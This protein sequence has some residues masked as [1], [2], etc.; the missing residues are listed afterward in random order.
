[1][2]EA[3]SP[4]QRGNNHHLG[5]IP[6]TRGNHVL[7]SLLWEAIHQ[8]LEAGLLARVCFIEHS[9]AK[10]GKLGIAHAGRLRVAVA[11]QTAMAESYNYIISSRLTAV[12]PGDDK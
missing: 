8:R 5:S 2:G 12:F 7:P 1:M 3:V 11:I 10:E 9:G 6:D 4:Y